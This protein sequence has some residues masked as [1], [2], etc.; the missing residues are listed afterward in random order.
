MK[1]Y[2]N[3]DVNFHL[4]WNLDEHWKQKAE[5][6]GIKSNISFFFFFCH[7]FEHTSHLDLFPRVNWVKTKC[8]HI[9]YDF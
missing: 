8:K 3:Y 7:S 9:I 2:Q 1:K 5:T 6:K 4:N